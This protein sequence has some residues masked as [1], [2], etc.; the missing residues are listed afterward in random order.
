MR[1]ASILFSLIILSFLIFNTSFTFAASEN[2]NTEIINQSSD[3]VAEST[4]QVRT[5]EMATGLRSSGMIWIVVGVIVIILVGLIIYLRTI[6]RK[7]T[8][9]EKEIK[10]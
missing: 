2:Q 5:P 1:I 9:L 6:D 7:I 4:Y 10:Q 8:K 3:T